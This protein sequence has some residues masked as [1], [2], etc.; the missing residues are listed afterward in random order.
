MFL[1]EWREF[2]SAPCPA[3][4]GGTFITARGSGLLKSRASITCFQACFVPGRAKDLLAPQYSY[5]YTFRLGLW[6][7]IV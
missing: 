4:G 6:P 7:L 3:G 2:P 5:A 1:S